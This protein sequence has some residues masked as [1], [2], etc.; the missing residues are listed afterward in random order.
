MRALARPIAVLRN[1]APALADH[2]ILQSNAG[3]PGKIVQG[4]AAALIISYQLFAAIIQ[5]EDPP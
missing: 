3:A 1:V 5:R 4:S 2:G